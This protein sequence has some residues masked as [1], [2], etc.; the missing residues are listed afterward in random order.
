MAQW[1]SQTRKMNRHYQSVIKKQGEIYKF[2]W[3]ITIDVRGYDPGTGEH[4]GS[5]S[6]SIGRSNNLLGLFGSMD[7][8]KDGNFMWEDHVDDSLDG[9]KIPAIEVIKQYDFNIPEEVSH[10]IE[11]SSTKANKITYNFKDFAKDEWLFNASTEE[12]EIDPINKSIDKIIIIESNIVKDASIGNDRVY[13]VYL[14]SSNSSTYY[15]VN[16]ILNKWHWGV[17]Y[18]VH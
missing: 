15:Y 6:F 3:G 9:N 10:E 13:G 1:Q 11:E 8:F 18:L 7:Y 16:N 5:L 12:P 14:E 4:T 17:A 2:Q